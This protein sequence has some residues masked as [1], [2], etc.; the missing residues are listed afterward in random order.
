MLSFCNGF[1]TIIIMYLMKKSLYSTSLVLTNRFFHNFFQTKHFSTFKKIIPLF[2]EILNYWDLFLKYWVILSSTKLVLRKYADFP[3]NLYICL[4]VLYYKSIQQFEHRFYSAI[5]YR[6]MF[7]RFFFFSEMSIFFFVQ[8]IWVYDP[9]ILKSFNFISSIA[10]FFTKPCYLSTYIYLHF[11]KSLMGYPTFFVINLSL[12]RI[13]SFNSLGLFLNFLVLA[14]LWLLYFGIC[15]PLLKERRFF[16]KKIIV[17]RLLALYFIF[18]LQ[19]IIPIFRVL[20]CFQRTL[21]ALLSEFQ[22]K[23]LF[24]QGGTYL[25]LLGFFENIHLYYL[26][27]KYSCI[28]VLCGLILWWLVD[29]KAVH[30]SFFFRFSADLYKV[31]LTFLLP[32][33]LCKDNYSSSYVACFF[34]YDEPS[35]F[36]KKHNSLF[37]WWGFPIPK[38]LV[39]FFFQQSTLLFKFL[40]FSFFYSVKLQKCLITKCFFRKN[41]AGCLVF[42]QKTMIKVRQYL[43]VQVFNMLSNIFTPSTLFLSIYGLLSSLTPL[44]FLGNKFFLIF[45][46]LFVNSYR[47]LSLFF[48]FFLTINLFCKN[49]I[50]NKLRFFLCGQILLVY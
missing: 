1:F 18:G 40:G 46:H 5:V 49:F 7:K 24:C 16:L 3:F 29:R 37:F 41:Y 22:W 47:Y 17:D 2:T 48:N 45:F 28:N 33:F 4:K 15:C 6:R 31:F 44:S 14:S 30:L 19:Q 23:L 12:F 35:F 43:Y 42:S 10:H 36:K 27:K 39:F 26:P 11:F 50:H 20:S 32:F 21:T 8:K 38:F 9:I 25:S 13:Y 34:F